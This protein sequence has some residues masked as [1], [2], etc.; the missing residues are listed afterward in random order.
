MKSVPDLLRRLYRQGRRRRS[1]SSRGCGTFR[2]DDT[3]NGVQCQ[4]KYYRGFNGFLVPRKGSSCYIYLAIHPGEVLCNKPRATVTLVMQTFE[5]N[6]KVLNHPNHSLE[7]CILLISLHTILFV[8][9]RTIPPKSMRQR[10][11]GTGISK[12]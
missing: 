12:V 11:R 1:S 10:C 3:A 7:I 2:V 8:A 9:R 4:R 5:Q 6:H